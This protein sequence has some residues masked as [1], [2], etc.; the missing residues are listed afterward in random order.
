M[1]LYSDSARYCGNI[2]MVTV[3]EALLTSQGTNWTV[4]KAVMCEAI[5]AF[6]VQ[7]YAG[8][9]CSNCVTIVDK[10][11]MIHNFTNTTIFVFLIY[12]T[13]L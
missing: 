1:T 4:V 12:S 5:F 7:S 11:I 10:F 6:V 8:F 13:G 3:Y 2:V 9:V